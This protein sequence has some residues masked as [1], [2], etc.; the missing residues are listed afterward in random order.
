MTVPTIT[1][2]ESTE[3]INNKGT[4]AQIIAVIGDSGIAAAPTTIH[5]FNSYEEAVTAIGP[6]AETNPLLAAV[7]DHFKE[8]NPTYEASELGVTKVYAI[9]VGS[10]PTPENFTDAMTTLSNVKDIELEE[11]H[12]LSTVTIL[13]SIATHL[14][15]LVSKGFPRLAIATV[16]TGAEEATILLMTD[17]G[18]T[19][20][21]QHSRVYIHIDRTMQSVFTAKV[22]CTPYYENPAHGS[23]RTKD[24]NDINEVT[25]PS[26]YVDK[27]FVCDWPTGSP[28]STSNQAEPVEAY[29]TAQA[30][31][32]VPAD[33]QMHVRRNADHQIRTICQM[34]AKYLKTRNVPTAR[35]VL[36][37]EI[38][39]HLANEVKA[40]KLEAGSADVIPNPTNTNGLVV[41]GS[42]RPPG[43]IDDITFNIGIELSTGGA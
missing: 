4:G 8:G 37:Q 30:A 23:Y 29:S 12:G 17:D 32:T 22:A 18:E 33:A 10:T 38:R 13:E 20:Y 9:N 1:V 5:T 40:E 2:N 39:G 31:S 41:N 11:Y 3:I 34:I 14:D 27:G 25:D 16:A 28:L 35:T 43:T 26:T 21:I 7:K 24:K 42:V 19:N 36:E 6:E 15:T